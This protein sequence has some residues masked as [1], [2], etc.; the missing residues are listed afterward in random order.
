[1]GFMFRSL[2]YDPDCTVV[3]WHYMHANGETPPEWWGTNGV[4][5]YAA[6]APR[7][8]IQHG[9]TEKFH[10][11]GGEPM[12]SITMRQL[13]LAGT[14]SM[15][16]LRTATGVVG[17]QWCQLLCGNCSSRVHSAWLD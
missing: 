9:W 6:I 12:V 5:Y 2:A 3:P 8:Y 15:V 17:N 4:N 10:R 16:G 14:F 13:L 1:M 7:G 11:S